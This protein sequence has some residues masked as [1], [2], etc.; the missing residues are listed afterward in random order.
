[1]N[2]IFTFCFIFAAILAGCVTEYQ[3]KEIVHLKR[4]SDN[5]AEMDRFI[6]IQEKG[7][8]RLQDDFNGNRLTAGTPKDSIISRYAEPVYCKA[9][10]GLS[11]G[12]ICLYRRPTEYFSPNVIFLYFNKDQQLE[13][14]ESLADGNKT[15]GSR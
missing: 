11:S 3:T 2:I 6:D 1:V 8:A 5:R 14:W 7:F 15:G 9:A 4:L 13:S 10:E 12:E